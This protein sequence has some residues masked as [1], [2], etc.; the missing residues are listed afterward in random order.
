M[1]AMVKAWND[2]KSLIGTQTGWNEVSKTGA[3]LHGDSGP[4][5]MA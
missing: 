2:M 1:N 5:A 4:A 3:V